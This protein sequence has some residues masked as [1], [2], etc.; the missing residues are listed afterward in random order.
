MSDNVG[1]SDS[2]ADP[3]CVTNSGDNKSACLP[4][5]S[6]SSC[7]ASSS[8]LIINE[9]SSGCSAHRRSTGSLSA[10]SFSSIPARLGP[11]RPGSALIRS[12]FLLSVRAEAGH[13]T[14]TT[15]S[16]PHQH[17]PNARRL[18]AQLAAASQRAHR[19]VP[20]RT[21]PAH[22]SQ[23]YFSHNHAIMN[24]AANRS[25]APRR[26]AWTRLSQASTHVF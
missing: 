2:H 12:V 3:R 4:P 10:A 23:L 15:R 25:V 19:R 11:V 18:D 21:R 16:V 17:V 14:L 22:G 13:V 1:G 8:P 20:H 9:S 24:F 5:K 6:L 7:V 26:S